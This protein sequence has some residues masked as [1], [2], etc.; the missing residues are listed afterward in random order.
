MQRPGGDIA[1]IVLGILLGLV[2]ALAFYFYFL[3]E[4]EPTA[5]PP[6]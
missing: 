4:F 5:R 2:V 1:S 6:L 3:T